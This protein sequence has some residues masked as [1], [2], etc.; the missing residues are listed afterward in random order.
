MRLPFSEIPHQSGLFTQYLN[1]P[2][3][4]KEFY[5]NAVDSP[6]GISSYVP[7]VLANYRTDRNELC[8]ALLDTALGINAG[9]ESVENIR[10]LRKPETVAVVT[11]QQAG[12]FT[13]P[14]YTI[15]KSLSAIKMAE[16][17][18]RRGIIAVPVFWAATEDHDFDEVAEASFL[19]KGGELFKSVYRPAN[20]LQDSPVGDIMIDGG[21]TDVLNSV[22]GELPATEFTGEIREMV[23]GIWTE[24]TF[25]GDAFLKTL[26]ALFSKH[27]LIFIDPMNRRIKKL[28]SA[29]YAD[30][31]RNVAAIVT[32][33]MGQS[34]NLVSRGYQAQ[35]LVEDDYFPLFWHDDAGR[36]T[37]LRKVKEGVFRAKSDKREFTVTELEKLALD[38]PQRFSPGVML[39]PVVQDFLLPTACYFGGGSEVAYFAQ[40]SAVYRVLDRPV[41]PV[42]HRQSFTIVEPKQ[43]RVSDKLHL[44]LPDLFQGI[45]KTILDVSETTLFPDTAKLFADVEEEVNMELNRLDQRLSQIDTT[46]AANLVKRRQKIIYHLGALRKKTYLA[47]VRK[48]RDISRQIGNLFAALLPNGELQ[49]RTVNVFSFLN[50]FGPN[51]IDWIYDAIDLKDKDHRI[52]DL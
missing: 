43:R 15:Y 49:E 33:V 17:L 44:S 31:I 35:V 34:R 38:E 7:A 3:S 30:A 42:F 21:L 23:S 22:F 50:K 51:F 47:Q 16:D 20:Y 1:D 28:S 27:G 9:D 29:I 6:F 12:L 36:R 46:L 4:L 41:T 39:R 26:A 48:D 14:L 2:V 52:V 10:T 37:A 5:P 32:G 13:G 18:T 40:N 19:S 8:D 45:E 24:G 11:G 25:F